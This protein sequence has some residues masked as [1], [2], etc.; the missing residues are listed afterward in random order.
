MIK[1][2]F[3]SLFLFLPISKAVYA[4]T[5]MSF[6]LSL[7]DE[8][9]GFCFSA[10]QYYGVAEKEVVIIR[11]KGIPD[12]E[13]P[14]VLFLASRARVT[15]D[16]IWRLRLQRKSWMDIS[17]HFGL[18]ADIFYVPVKGVFGPPYGNAYGYYSK[19]PRNKWKKIVLKDDDIIN[20]VNLR[21]V[22]EHY[23]YAPEEVIKMRIKGIDFVKINNEIKIIKSGKKTGEE[24]SQKGGKQ[25]DRQFKS[26]GKKR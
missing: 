17:L 13:I 23:G 2:L 11:E 9:R 14:V 22:S 8:R 7:G 15:P 12:D 10:S 6:G 16:A 25:K 4:E 3:L 21:F 1:I 5:E 20:F 26:R 24:K 19:T 18:G